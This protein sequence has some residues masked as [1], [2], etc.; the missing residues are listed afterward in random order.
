M[1][2]TSYSNY[3]ASPPGKGANGSTVNGS[4]S[5]EVQRG[6]APGTQGGQVEH[7]VLKKK[8]GCCVI[9]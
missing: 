1:N 3:N 4:G 8:K 2:S 7:V 5:L 9:Q 6:V